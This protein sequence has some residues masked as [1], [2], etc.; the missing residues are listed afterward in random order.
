MRRRGAG[1]AAGMS[2]VLDD[3]A[4][5]GADSS[6]PVTPDVSWWLSRWYA[7]TTRT[8]EVAAVVT[9]EERL[10]APATAHLRSR[11]HFPEYAPELD[12]S[13]AQVV[14]HLTESCQVFRGRVA[15]AR[16]TPGAEVPDFDPLTRA[17]EWEGVPMQR[18]LQDLA[19]AMVDLATEVVRCETVALAQWVRRNGRPQ[20]LRSLL[21]FTVTHLEDH[22]VQLELLAR[23]PAREKLPDTDLASSPSGRGSATAG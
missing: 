8:T 7:L 10:D 6:R 20:T 1:H 3:S 21:E 16:T 18:L 11:G 19:R 22:L 23:P 14:G 2:E 17:P 12:W 13:A 9:G 5:T 15:T 4:G